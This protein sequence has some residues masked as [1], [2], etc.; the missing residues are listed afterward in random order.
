[1]IWDERLDENLRKADAY[2]GGKDDG[3]REGIQKGIQE[4]IQ[5]TKE[6]MVRNMYKKKMDVET[7]SQIANLKVS[8]IQKIINGHT[9]S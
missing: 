5:N 9:N 7:I 8:E 3:I 6:E 4:G 2:F 1:M